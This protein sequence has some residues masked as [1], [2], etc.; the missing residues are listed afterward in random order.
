MKVIDL[1]ERISDSARVEIYEK[2]VLISLFDGKNSIDDKY[3]NRIVKS[4]YVYNDAVK[5]D[6]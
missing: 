1:L 5:I 6:I 3:N 2:G 4:F